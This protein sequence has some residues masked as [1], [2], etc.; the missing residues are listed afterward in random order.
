MNWSKEPKD[1]RNKETKVLNWSKEPK[2]LR[3]KE[4]KVSNGLTSNT[5]TC[6]EL[7]SLKKD[8]NEIKHYKK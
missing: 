3:N 7:N 6:K 5:C 4:T 8:L 1:L 2:D